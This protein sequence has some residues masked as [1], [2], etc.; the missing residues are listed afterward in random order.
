[1]A[2]KRAGKVQSAAGSARNAARDALG[3]EAVE[4]SR[5]AEAVRLLAPRG[6]C[7]GAFLFPA[8]A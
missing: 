6:G 5:T 7:P 8:G 3:Q 4:A 1:M 2:G